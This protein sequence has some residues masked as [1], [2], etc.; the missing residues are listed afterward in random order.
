MNETY[1]TKRGSHFAMCR[2]GGFRKCA[3]DKIA[4]LGLLVITLLIAYFIIVS[5]S[6]IVL[7]EPIELSYTGLSVSIPAGN[8]WRS[9]KQWKY[10]ENAFTLGSF[11]YPGTRRPIAKAYCQYL[12]AATEAAPDIWFK[13]KASEVGGAIVKT[14][15]T[16]T[17]ELTFDWAHIKRQET[18]LD[19]F[20]G[21]AQL[22]NHR[23]LDIEVHQTTGDTNLAERVFKRITESLEFK[24]NQL[25]E[26]G[27]EIVAEIKSKGLPL[28]AF[29]R[30]RGDNQSRE[31]FFLIKDAARHT[32][33]FTMDVLVDIGRDAQLNIQAAS[34]VYIRG[35]YAREQAA[36]FQGD[37]SFDEF[38]WKSETS[39]LVGRRGAEI[40]LE[41]YGAMTVKKFGRRVEEKNYQLSSAAIP[42]VFL[43]LTFG[44]MLDSNHKKIIVD[45]IEADGTITPALV[46]RVEAKDTAVAEDAAAYVLKREFLNGRGF[47]ERVYFN[48]RYQVSK[49]LLRQQSIYTLERTS[50][51]DIVKQFPERADYILQKNKM[52]EHSN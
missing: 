9:E 1:E 12:L 28:L 37:N 27:S 25:L 7:S 23:Q 30:K 42:D 44:Q 18:P 20:F 31:D 8:G 17:G 38:A 13:Q 51:E 43:D 3:A 46:S 24:G 10:R 47:S 41:K 32:I 40:I 6:A 45:I 50:A 2:R 29:A 11:F 26:A 34:F 5:R 19:L 33:G 52:L 16:R 48:D 22:Q 39:S 35:Q 4:L 14:G 15:K 36:F 21:T 49:R